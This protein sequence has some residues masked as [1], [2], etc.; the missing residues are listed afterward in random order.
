MT[1][2]EAQQLV[3]RRIGMAVSIALFTGSTKHTFVQ[4]VIGA[5]MWREGCS[6]KSFKILN[7]VGVAL[8]SYG[9]RLNVTRLQD[10]HDREV[11]LWKGEVEVSI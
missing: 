1:A 10:D 4:S 11:K 9:S 2:D 6:P 5:E 7:G 8:N 3:D